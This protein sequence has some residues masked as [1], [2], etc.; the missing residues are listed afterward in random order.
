MSEESLLKQ[1]EEIRRIFPDDES[2]QKWVES[3]MPSQEHKP[4][5]DPVFGSGWLDVGDRTEVDFR[6]NPD[7]GVFGEVPLTVTSNIEDFDP[8]AKEEAWELGYT[9]KTLPLY[10]GPKPLEML[11]TAWDIGEGLYMKDPMQVGT[12]ALFG[13]SMGPVGQALLAGFSLMYPSD[14]EGHPIKGLENLYSA[15]LEKLSGM[16]THERG[17]IVKRTPEQWL[18]GLGNDLKRGRQQIPIKTRE[19]DELVAFIKKHKLQDTKLTKDELINYMKSNYHTQNIGSVH[20]VDGFGRGRLELTILRPADSADASRVDSFPNYQASDPHYDHGGVLSFRVIDDAS[21]SSEHNLVEVQNDGASDMQAFGARGSDKAIKMN[22]LLNW[23]DPQPGSNVPSLDQI[24]LPRPGDTLPID[25]FFAR[26]KAQRTDLFGEMKV[27]ADAEGGENTVNFARKIKERG[28]SNLAEDYLKQIHRNI[29]QIHADVDA[30]YTDEYLGSVYDV[31]NPKG[32]TKEQFL[33][34]ARAM[35][36]SNVNGMLRDSREFRS[37]VTNKFNALIR[38]YPAIGRQLDA[39]TGNNTTKWFDKKMDH[40]VSK[41]SPEH[42]PRLSDIDSDNLASANNILNQVERKLVKYQKLKEKN[43]KQFHPDT[44]KRIRDN[45]ELWAKIGHISDDIPFMKNNDWVEFE[46]KKHLT[47]AV[48]KDAKIVKLPMENPVAVW[49]REEGTPN[50]HFLKS[51]Y[52][53][54]KDS[55]GKYRGKVGQ[56]LQQLEK[57]YGIKFEENMA[58]IVQ[59][60]AAPMD[61]VIHPDHQKKFRSFFP[62]TINDLSDLGGAGMSELTYRWD[63]FKRSFAASETADNRFLFSEGQSE[64]DQYFD[65]AAGSEDNLLQKFLVDENITELLPFSRVKEMIGAS[66][67]LARGQNEMVLN[68]YEN[69]I[70][71]MDHNWRYYV[72]DHIADPEELLQAG[73]SSLES[74][75]I[76]RDNWASLW[77]L[78][79]DQAMQEMPKETL[80]ILKSKGVIKNDPGSH[81][82]S[83]VIVLD[84]V[85]KEQII[86]QG[87]PISGL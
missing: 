46:I 74:P 71:N 30:F 1:L 26:D 80:D 57:K 38:E 67:K 36:H 19:I 25:T 55:K 81:R 2:F 59:K 16:P 78:S 27:L 58:E 64:A 4:E 13:R 17:Q 50:W 51:I 37:M 9:L 53:V 86:E 56:V 35:I 42:M 72:E 83:F 24:L 22:D 5:P 43:L 7:F 15:V 45:P 76:L 32:I 6:I 60:D 61:D 39:E 41:W 14:A 82:S 3:G 66:K 44:Q 85:L 21:P 70:D 40:W 20:R 87:F 54:S 65:R 84:D 47:E 52:G 73:F 63:R 28:A 29:E 18:R 11:A 77:N 10:F 49:T 68:L 23:R 79:V 34:S 31:A 75:Y 12:A 33:V 69:I 48:K 8:E 62:H